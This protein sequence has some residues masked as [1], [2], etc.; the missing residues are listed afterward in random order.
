MAR[1]CAAPG[2]QDEPGQERPTAWWIDGWLYAMPPA[3]VWLGVTVEDQRRADERIPRL[4]EI[5]A[6]VRFLS[7]EP[8]LENVDLLT[9]TFNGADS[10][11]ALAGLHWIIV[12]GES[13]TRARPFD[14]RWARSIME[15]CARADVACFVKQMGAAPV[16]GG[17]ELLFADPKGGDPDG[18]PDE[19][20]VREIPVPQ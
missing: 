17:A 2:A 10:F 7:C 14:V 20:R 3:N 12:G 16:E 11:G 19:L 5:P 1:T 4:L 9:P 13:G 18:W 6:R 15:Q 8:L